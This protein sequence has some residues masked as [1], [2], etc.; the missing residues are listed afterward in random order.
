MRVSYVWAIPPDTG[1]I[2][3]QRG[4]GHPEMACGEHAVDFTVNTAA[5]TIAVTAFYSIQQHLLLLCLFLSLFLLLLLLGLR[6]HGGRR[7]H[8]RDGLGEGGEAEMALAPGST[9]I[10]GRLR[11]LPLL[12]FLSP[13][14]RAGP[15]G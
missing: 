15:K 12:L 5:I 9:Q 3:G 10:Q 6:L 2:Q 7:P 4:R 13:G 11:D 14:G 8:H 1:H